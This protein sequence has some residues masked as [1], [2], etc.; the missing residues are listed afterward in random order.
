V[1]ALLGVNG[2]GKTSA[3]EVLEGLAG[4]EW[5]TGSST[6]ALHRLQQ[7]DAE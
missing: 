5:R 6:V 4:V 1:F 3:L 2:A 7:Q